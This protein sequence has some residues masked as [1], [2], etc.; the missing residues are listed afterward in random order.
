MLKGLFSMLLNSDLR[1]S[2]VAELT[3]LKLGKSM[4]V[5]QVAHESFKDITDM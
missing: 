5:V 2:K 1:Q 4:E 3:D